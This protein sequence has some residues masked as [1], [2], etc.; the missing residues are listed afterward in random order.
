[1][2]MGVPTVVDAGT[3]AWDLLGGRSPE[4]A[5]LTNPR[6][7]GMIVTPREIDL[8]IDRAAQLV[9][10]AINC[11]LQPGLDSETLLSLTED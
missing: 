7:A 1:M 5:E 3:L 2:S 9:A 11:A 10:Q 4:D 6:G 8:L